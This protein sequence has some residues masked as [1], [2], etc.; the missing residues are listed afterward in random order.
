M[1]QI[2]V[3]M[4]VP[5][6]MERCVNS[7]TKRHCALVSCLVLVTLIVR[8]AEPD[9]KHFPAVLPPPVGNEASCRDEST[10]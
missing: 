8:A 4:N 5:I 6:N 3:R 9:R 10:I 1:T 2:L 7:S